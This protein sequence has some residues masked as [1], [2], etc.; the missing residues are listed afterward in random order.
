ML[1]SLTMPKQRIEPSAEQIFYNDFNN[2]LHVEENNN[3]LA[4]ALNLGPG[5]WTVSDAGE[6]AYFLSRE[7][8][9]YIVIDA[10]GK[11]T[12]LI[13]KKSAPLFLNLLLTRDGFYAAI[14]GYLLQ[15]KRLESAALDFM[16]MRAIDCG[17]QFMFRLEDDGRLSYTKRGSSL[18]YYFSSADRKKTTA[19][20]PKTI[21]RIAFYDSFVDGFIPTMPPEFDGSFSALR[22]A[23]QAAAKNHKISDC[24]TRLF[25]ILSMP[26]FS[27][28]T[29]ETFEMLLNIDW[30]SQYTNCSNNFF[31]SARLFDILF[32]TTDTQTLLPQKTVVAKMLKW[33]KKYENALAI[34]QRA[35]PLNGENFKTIEL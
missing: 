11:K 22:E 8:E 19:A 33:S 30:F 5:N 24:G 25:A 6:V 34:G 7:N 18:R 21:W 3:T 20:D 28:G 35:K 15:G 12:R 10:P 16:G 31:P 27:S 26:C 1:P 4:L 9:Q 2:T 32:T 17:A 29:A 23:F 13:Q 14:P